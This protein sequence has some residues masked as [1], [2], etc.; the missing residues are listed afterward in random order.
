M[1]PPSRINFSANRSNSFVVAPGTTAR[2]ISRNALAANRPALRI[3]SKSAG[4]FN[5]ILRDPISNR[6]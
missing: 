3:L 6:L 4:D 5:S 2:P 1:P